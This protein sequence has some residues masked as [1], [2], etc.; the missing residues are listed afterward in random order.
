MDG[1]KPDQSNI[2]KIEFMVLYIIQKDMLKFCLKVLNQK[3]N[4]QIQR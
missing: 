1:K 3:S 2:G 4:K